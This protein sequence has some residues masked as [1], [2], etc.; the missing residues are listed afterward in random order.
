ML[1][2]LWC[3]YNHDA[4]S[5]FEDKSPEAFYRGLVALSVLCGL[6][7]AGMAVLVVRARNKFR[8]RLLVLAHFL[9]K[10]HFVFLLFTSAGFLVFT[11]S[12]H[13]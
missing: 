10:K 3:G 4:I 8:E 9:V 1:L 6:R 13:L 5:S 11:L 12:L 2:F 7:F